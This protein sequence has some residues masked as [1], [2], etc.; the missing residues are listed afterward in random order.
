VDQAGAIAVDSLGNSYVTGLSVGSGSGFDYATIKYLATAWT[1]ESPGPQASGYRLGPNIVR[2]SLWLEQGPGC[3][4]QAAG[5]L[6]DAAGRKKLALRPGMN[7]VAGLGPG[8]YFVQRDGQP[9]SAKTL[10]VR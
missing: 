5:W 3:A 6:L 2:G 9:G 4:P 10:V 7:D 1:E 8:V